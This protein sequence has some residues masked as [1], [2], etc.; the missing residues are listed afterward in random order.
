MLRRLWGRGRA[1]IR[2]FFLVVC[3]SKAYMEWVK[4]GIL[5]LGNENACT[6]V[7][8]RDIY[9]T[10]GLSHKTSNIDADY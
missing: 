5:G 8:N 10:M 2:C 6:P 7:F 4:F 9:L 1:G 3:I